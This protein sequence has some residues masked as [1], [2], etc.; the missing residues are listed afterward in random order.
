MAKKR[1]RRKLAISSNPFEPSGSGAPLRED[2]F[3][4]PEQSWT[5]PLHRHL[6]QLDS[7]S[8]RR[9]IA[10]IGDYGSG[11]SYILRWMERSE[12]PARNVLPFYFENPEV[13]FYDLANSLLRRI[14]RKHFAKLLFELSSQHRRRPL[15]RSLF[16]SGFD[17]YLS[18]SPMK[19]SPY[20]IED[21]QEALKRAEVTD[22]DQIAHCLARV[23]VETRKKPYFEYRDFVST[24]SGAYVAER[25]EARYFG[26]ILKVLRLADGV[27]R[28]AFLLDEFEQVS[29]QRKLTRK[30]AQD[31]FVTLKRLLDVTDEGD[32]WLI[33]AMTPDAAEKTGALDPAF[34]DRCYRFQIPALEKPDA[35]ALV[36]ERFKHVDAET[37]PF[38]PGFID[39]LQPTTYGSPRR[40][41]KVFHVATN[42]AMKLGKS[43]SKEQLSEIDRELYPAEDVS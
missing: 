10:V 42:K 26:A 40:L 7:G 38:A 14:G 3:W 35:E 21:F 36:K 27:D 34:W 31:Y 25:Q 5:K 24:R 28:V 1:Q 15:Q 43:L 11:K 33:L 37:I 16:D 32:L 2:K 22:D 19:A 30:D 39:A 17:T 9:A 12:F 4:F 8:G 23:I 29:L 20:E 41:V 6:D 18:H 13:K